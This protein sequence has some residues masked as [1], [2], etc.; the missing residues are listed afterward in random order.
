M[1]LETNVG[2]ELLVVHTMEQITIAQHRVMCLLWYFTNLEIQ[3][4]ILTGLLV[5]R[6]IQ[7]KAQTTSTD[8]VAVMD[9]THMSVVFPV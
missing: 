9:K 5:E 1:M 6:V 4:I 3:I 8:V 7:T 2:V